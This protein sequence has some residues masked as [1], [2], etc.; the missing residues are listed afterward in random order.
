MDNVRFFTDE[1]TNDVYAVISNKDGSQTHV[2]KL[3][4]IN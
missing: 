2:G 4:F 3:L 1:L